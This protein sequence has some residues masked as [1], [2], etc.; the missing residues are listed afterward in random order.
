MNF[1]GDTINVKNGCHFVNSF[2][3]L[4]SHYS[5]ILRLIIVKIAYLHGSWR[6]YRRSKL[7]NN[8]FVASNQMKCYVLMGSETVPVT[9][10]HWIPF[11]LLCVGI[12]LPMSIKWIKVLLIQCLYF[13]RWF[14]FAWIDESNE[15]DFTLSIFLQ[16]FCFRLAKFTYFAAKTHT[17]QTIKSN[18]TL[19]CDEYLLC[20]PKT[21]SSC[22]DVHFIM[23]WQ[24]TF[25]RR[26]LDSCLISPVWSERKRGK[27]RT[28]LM[29][30]VL[31]EQTI[32]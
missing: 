32:A 23:D 12:L 21:F 28:I 16:W 1:I 18:E 9:S 31:G 4:F 24:K 7:M 25:H 29:K 15:N 17:T 30:V 8:R 14:H 11:S 22:F 13:S 3:W 19:W 26:R 10:N 27:S 20:L 5:F 2:E 6:F